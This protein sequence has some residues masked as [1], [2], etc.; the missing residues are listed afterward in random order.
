MGYFLA[1]IF[2][3]EAIKTT[4]SHCMTDVGLTLKCCHG[5]AVE[6]MTRVYGAAL[7]VRKVI[8]FILLTYSFICLF[9]QDQL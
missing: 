5:N 7:S 1:L 8:L 9:A 6:S 3:T 4:M 2:R